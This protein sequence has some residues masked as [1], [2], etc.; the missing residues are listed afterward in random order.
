MTS[1]VKEGKLGDGVRNLAPP[2]HAL[3]T[4]PT[5]SQSKVVYVHEVLWTIL[6]LTDTCHFFI[7]LVDKCLQSTQQY[8]RC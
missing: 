2:R 8:P 6:A 3:P 7:L 5:M 1:Q 4:S